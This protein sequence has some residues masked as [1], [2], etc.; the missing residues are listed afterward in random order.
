MKS[1]TLSIHKGGKQCVAGGRNSISCANSQHTPGISIHHFPDKNKDYERYRQWIRF[2]RRHRP[3]W[4]PESKQTI[5][6]RVHFE[7]SCFTMRRELANTLGI[8]LSLK[9]DAVPTIDSANEH[10]ANEG[11]SSSREKRKVSDDSKFSFKQ[12]FSLQYYIRK[13]NHYNII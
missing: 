8:K 7:D 13:I 2:L 10:P 12:T 6:C 3:N 11:V 5:L 1:A 4:T 9:P